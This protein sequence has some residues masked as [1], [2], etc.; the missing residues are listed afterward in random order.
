LVGA[1]LAPGVARGD[2]LIGVTT[3]N[4]DSAGI[5]GFCDCLAGPDVSVTPTCQDRYDQDGDEDVDLIDLAL[6]QAGYAGMDVVEAQLAGNALTL[7]PFFEYVAAF[8]VNAPVKVGLDPTRYPELVGVTADLYVVADKTEEQ[9]HADPT[10]TDVRLDGPQVVTFG[11]TTIQ[12]NTFQV[13]EANELDADAGTGLGVGYDVVIDANR[14]AVVDDGDYIDGYRHVAGFYVVADTVALG[15]LATTAIQYSGGAWLGQRTWYPTDIAALGQLPLVVISHGNGHNY[16][17]YD[18]LQQHLA[19]YGYIVMSHE[20][21]TGPGIESASTT[22]LTNTDYFLGHLATIGNGVFNGHVDVHKIMWIGHSRGG[23]GVVRAY[24]RLYDGYTPVNYTLDDVILVS[25]IAPTDFLGPEQSDPHQV[26]YHLIYGAA[27]GDVGGYPGNDVADAFNIYERAQGFRQAT[28]VHGADHN[29]FNCCGVDDFEGPPGTAIGR[30]EAQRVAKAAYLALVK[31]YVEGNVPAKDFLWRQYEDLRPIG[32]AATDTVDLEYKEGTGSFFVD[33]FQTQPALGISSSGGAVTYNVQNPYEG[34]MNDTDGSFAWSASDPM[35]G[36]TRARTNDTTKGLVFDWTILG[37]PFLEFEVVPAARDVSS[38]EYLSFRAC[39]QTRHPQTTSELGDLTFTVSLRDADGTVSSINIGAYGGG[40][41]EPYQRTGYGTGA[42]WQ[43]EFE[44]IRVRL[45]DFLRNGAALDLTNIVAVRFSFGGGAGSLR[46]RIGFD[47]LQFS[48]D[49]EPGGLTIRPL[50]LPDHIPPGQPTPVQVKIRGR[51]ET[52]VPDTGRLHFRYDDGAY[53]TVP[54]VPVGQDV[55]AAI[56]PAPTCSDQPQFYFTA[57]GS[58]SGLIA[59]PPAAPASVYLV[60][61]GEWVSF[62]EQLMNTDPGW[63]ISGGLWAFGQPTGGGGQHGGP[64]PTSGCTGPSVYGYNLNGDY[65]PNM[66]ERH[67]TMPAIDCTGLTGVR[68]SFWRW[69]G[70]EQPAYDHAR[71]RISTDGSTWAMV[72]ENGGE[73]A[74]T[75]WTFQAFDISSIADD[76]STVYVRWTMGMTDE[77]WEY[78]G[79]NIDDVHLSM[80][81]CNED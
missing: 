21:N 65:E 47:D 4:E 71:L 15:P 62:F 42:G 10:L 32:V 77:S 26:D 75:A 61:V 38:Y 48:K 17:W 28:Y 7:Y 74:D 22:T 52:Y 60:A 12:Q 5:Q 20:N 57:E 34:L 43:N 14:N 24:D 35:N 55:Y 39:Q 30:E 36:M 78:C 6:W 1:L 76:Q 27:D 50:S 68:L 73:V 16:T 58:A 18:Y 69:L 80:F 49:P 72:W 25:S 64:D 79:W 9:W 46:G 33:D 54:L 2:R 13:A 53:N 8:N 45:G 37:A 44:T 66:P 3:G 59:D 70:V 56:L 40:I 29:D 31:H 19:S 67:L 63:A 51:S 23:E 11:G 41:E 81:A